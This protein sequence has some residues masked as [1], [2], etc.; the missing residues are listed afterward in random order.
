FRE[1]ESARGG[2]PGQLLRLVR[3][4]E[5]EE[6]GAPE[7]MMEI[8]VRFD[9]IAVEGG[10][11]LVPCPLAELDELAVLHH[12]DRLPREL[13]RGH[14]LRGGGQ[15]VEELEE[16]PIALGHGIEALGVEAELAQPV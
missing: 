15:P 14:P 3:Y 13:Y 5:A 11:H 9:D 2:A 1:G 4:R 10:R 12:R 6:K 8:L 16:R 7:L